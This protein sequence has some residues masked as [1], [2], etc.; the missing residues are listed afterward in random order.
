MSY[1]PKSKCRYRTATNHKGRLGVLGS[2]LY[3]HV[4][5]LVHKYTK[6]VHSSVWNRGS[7]LPEERRLEDRLSSQ[8]NATAHAD[9]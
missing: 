2:F 6:K 5:D 4:T 1:E 8:T 7:V 3:A 9:S